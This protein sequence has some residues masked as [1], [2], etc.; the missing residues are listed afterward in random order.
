M[1]VLRTMTQQNL[2]IYIFV[3]LQAFNIFSRTRTIAMFYLKCKIV[4]KPTCDSFHYLMTINLETVQRISV[5]EVTCRP[6][7]ILHFK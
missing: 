3:V 2:Q 7:A 6:R 5:T 1:T 4:R